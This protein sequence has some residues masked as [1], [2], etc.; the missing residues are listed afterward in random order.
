MAAGPVTV[1]I[2]GIRQLTAG[3]ADLF[4]NIE[5]RVDADAVQVTAD[6]AAATIR[7][8]VP[9]LTG[10]LASTVRVV[11]QPGPLAQVTMGGGLPYARWIEF[12]QYRGRAPRGG[13]YVYPTAKRT[14]RAFRKHCETTCTTQIRRER[15]PTPR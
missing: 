10:R 1:K 3:A 8:R 12:G 14:E 13:R 6:Q 15:W 9:K 11:G 5:D 2:R 7:A 4:E